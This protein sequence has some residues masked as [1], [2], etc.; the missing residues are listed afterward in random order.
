MNCVRGE[1][2]IR[3]Y[4]FSRKTYSADEL[5]VFNHGGSSLNESSEA[6]GHEVILNESDSEARSIFTKL[7][8][9]FHSNPVPVTLFIVSVITTAISCA[10][11]I[12][13]MLGLG[14]PG[15]TLDDSWIHLQFA[16]T[17]YEGTP[18]EYSPSY[19]STGSTS[20]LWS[21]L[22]S[23]IFFF[24][25][26]T[27]SVVWGVLMISIL[28]FIA[29]SFL[30]GYLIQAYT[31]SSLWGI[32][33]ILG[34][35]ILPRNTWLMLSGMETPLFM[36]I[37]LFSIYLLDRTDLK[38]DLLLGVFA[39][40]AYLSRP[41]GVLIAVLL[42]PFR[43]LMLSYKRQVNRKR[44]LTLIIS[45]IVA[46]IIVLPWIL[47]CINVTGLP[48]PDTFYAKV[49]SPTDVEKEAWDIWWYFFVRE[50]YFLLFG[51]SAGVFLLL[52]GKP[53]PWILAVSLTILYRL[54]AP[55]AS[56]IN[57]ARYLVPIFDLFLIAAVVFAAWIIEASF[58]KLLKVK[59]TMDVR[60]L[61]VIA[62]SI[63][64]L[65]PLIPSYVSQADYFTKSV[66]TINDM[67][68]GIGTWLAE[69]TPEDAVFATHDA[70]AIRYISGRRMIDLA[71]LLSPDIIHGNMSSTET[72]RYLRQ[73]G[74]NYFVFFDELFIWWTLFLPSNA[75]ERI[76]TVHIPP[77]IYASAGRDTMSVFQIYWEN[78][79]Y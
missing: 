79:T 53:F 17:I 31:E 10:Y 48:L 2:D 69:N 70:G 59:G 52:K 68:V 74:C 30:V 54:S 75:Y 14:N 76:Y 29:C 11:Y 39:G 13:T 34:F 44:I 8:D 3:K 47:H 7:I 41:E 5:L 42:I 33:G 32:V 1:G 57:N 56:L 6:K 55:Y 23:V 73:Q 28:F 62:I 18:W 77:E 35:V 78:T 65:V 40:L 20:P 16:R 61:S 66:R 43:F 63:L 24:T 50:M 21:I 49:H 60:Y 46:I 67:H 27:I 45:G 22:L 71:G 15:F 26:D 9:W 64:L 37:L 38:A 72:L 4:P 58:E 51:I 36:F 19:P 25:S 12:S